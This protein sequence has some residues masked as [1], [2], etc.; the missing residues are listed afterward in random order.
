MRKTYLRWCLRGL[1]VQ[2]D[3]CHREH[4]KYINKLISSNKSKYPSKYRITFVFMRQSLYRLNR[5]RGAIAAFH[6]LYITLRSSAAYKMQICPV[7]RP[8]PPHFRPDQT[9]P[10]HDNAKS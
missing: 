10:T 2:A 6:R 7:T 9:R 5:H 4:L 3:Q 1:A 8:D